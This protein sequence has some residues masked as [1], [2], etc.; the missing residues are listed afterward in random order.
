MAFGYWTKAIFV[1]VETRLVTVT[2][3]QP[4]VWASGDRIRRRAAQRVDATES[5]ELC[6]PMLVFQDAIPDIRREVSGIE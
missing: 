5:A 1:M 6:G 3:L 2:V 4:Y